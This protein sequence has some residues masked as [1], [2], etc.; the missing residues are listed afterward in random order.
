M[1]KVIDLSIGALVFR[2]GKLV[3]LQRKDNGRWDFPKG[4]PVEG[5]SDEQ[6]LRRELFEECGIK[7]MTIMKGFREQI[8]YES[9]RGVLRRMIVYAVTTDDL[10]MLSPEHSQHQLVSIDRLKEF[11]EYDD[12]LQMA[13]K[14]NNIIQQVS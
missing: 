7:N 12:I 3:V 5:E 2:A 10:I 1:N 4:H 9:S 14:A 8:E 6:T 11:F 13:I